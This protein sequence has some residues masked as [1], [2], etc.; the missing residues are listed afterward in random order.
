MSLTYRRNEM[1]F[2]KT[3]LSIDAGI[4]ILANLIIIT[5]GILIVCEVIPIKKLFQTSKGEK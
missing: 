4:F 2:L 5:L 3:F 1:I